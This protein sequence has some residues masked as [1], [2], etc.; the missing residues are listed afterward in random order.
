MKEEVSFEDFDKVDLRV[1][2]IVSVEPIEK[3]KKLLKLQVDF[4]VLGTR[5]ILA[6][7]SADY[8]TTTLLHMNVA[9]VFNLAPRTMFGIESH[10]MLLATT[11]L[12]G[13]VTLLTFGSN[14]VPGS[15][16]G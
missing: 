15:S 10:G 1:G 8:T 6:G 13:K 11:T 4:G 2:Q 14:V 16:I 9:V 3:S 7:I 5:T 12:D